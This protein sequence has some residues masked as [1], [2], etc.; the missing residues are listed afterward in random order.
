MKKIQKK[1][2][3]IV[4]VITS[5]NYDDIVTSSISPDIQEQLLSCDVFE[6][7]ADTFPEKEITALLKNLR[8]SLNNSQNNEYNLLFTLRLKRDGGQWHK[9]SELRYPI[10]TDIVTSKL[11]NWIDIEMEEIKKTPVFLLNKMKKCLIK[12]LLSHHNFKNT[13]S[14]PEFLKITQQMAK[15]VPDIVKFAVTANSKEEL[16]ILL[17][18]STEL[19]QDFP[20][21]CLMSMGEY[22]KLSRISSPIIGSPITFGYIG[23]S[24]VI[25]G[26]IKVSKLKEK[27]K[28]CQEEEILKMDNLI[29]IFEQILNE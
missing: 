23:D 12:L 17:Q 9:E 7:R 19:I 3:T 8:F 21:S 13:Y 14:K 6:F 29:P 26:Q 4:G 10:M 22:G 11:A 28:K 20:E 15:F 2:F 5:D 16:E 27:L 18:F 25:P 1:N 24:A